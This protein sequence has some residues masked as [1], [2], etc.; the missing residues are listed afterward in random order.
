MGP[1]RGRILGA[2]AAVSLLAGCGSDGTTTP[3][4]S[5]SPTTGTCATG[6]PVAGTPRPGRDPR[7]E[8]P[9]EPARPAVC[10]RRSGAAVR[11]RAARAD[12]HRARRDARGRPVPRHR[13]AG[14]LLR[15][16]RAAGPGLPPGLRAERPLLRQL[17]EP[18]GEHARLRVPRLVEPGRGGSRHRA[19][20]PVRGASPSRTTTAAAWPSAATAGSTSAS[21]TAGRAAIP[22]ATARTSARTWARCCASTWTPARPTPCPPTTRSA[23]PRRRG[24]RSGRWACAT[25]GASPST[26]ARRALHRATWARARARRSTWPRPAAAG[27]TTAGT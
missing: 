27:R 12:P 21:A 2:C 24:R 11:G 13:L 5:P 3:T 25:R 22:R 18:A 6:A 4:P 15:R 7:R 1:G 14:Q 10:A 9:G 17:H 8:R 20:A 19:A 16:A 23:R 26:A